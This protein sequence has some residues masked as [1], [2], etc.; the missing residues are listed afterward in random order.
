MS[1]EL[2]IGSTIKTKFGKTATVKS[3]IAEGGQ[4]FVYVVDYDGHDMALKWYK[5]TGLGNDPAGFYDNIY[6]NVKRGTPSKEFLW[7]VDITE[8]YDSTFG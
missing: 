5:Q 1:Q 3:Y 6:Q 4:G 7:P 2:S 8:W